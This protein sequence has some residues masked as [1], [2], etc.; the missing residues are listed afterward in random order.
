MS[1]P[2]GELPWNEVP[3]ADWGVS[4]RTLRGVSAA[5]L[6]CSKDVEKST[7]KDEYKERE[8]DISISAKKI[9][10]DYTRSESGGM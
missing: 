4:N 1:L 6:F 9:C 8:D 10:D 3:L 5:D 7:G 2:R